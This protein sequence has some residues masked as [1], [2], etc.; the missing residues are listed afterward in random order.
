MSLYTTIY[1]KAE[2]L[3]PEYREVIG[4]ISA[5]LGKL[6]EHWC[7]IGDKLI[8]KEYPEVAEAMDGGEL[9]NHPLFSTP[10]WFCLFSELSNMENGSFDAEDLLTGEGVKKKQ[11]ALTLH[12]AGQVPEMVIAASINHGYEVV[13]LFLSW[14]CFGARNVKT[15]VTHETMPYG[16]G[17]YFT[18][19]GEF[20]LPEHLRG[21]RAL[22]EG[23]K[24]LSSS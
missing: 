9:L 8:Q 13:T 19:E 14:I 20:L 5:A 3:H 21:L 22:P 18:F 23:V 16:E 10:R 15:W 11:S 12:P 1:F 17:P 4:R 24:A 6:P 2:S 7:L